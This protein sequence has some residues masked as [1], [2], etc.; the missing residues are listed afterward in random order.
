MNIHGHKLKV[1]KL[2]GNIKEVEEELNERN[3]TKLEK[4]FLTRKKENILRKKQ[5]QLN[6]IKSLKEN[7]RIKRK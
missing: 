3:L 7:K 1:I 4:A 5:T 6:I 2:K